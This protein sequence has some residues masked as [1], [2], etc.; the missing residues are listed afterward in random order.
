MDADSW[1]PDIYFDMVEEH[2]LKNF[3]NR[4]KLFYQ[5]PQI[6]TRNN[7]DVPVFTRV[8]DVIHSFIHVSNLFSIFNITFPLSNYTVSYNLVKRFGFWDTCADAIGED[9]HTLQKSFWKTNAE[10]K[11]VPIYTPFNQVNISTG[12]K[13]IENVLARFWQAERHAQGVAD[14]AW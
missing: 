14:I 10:V 9:F 11:T 6:F 12:D 1:A 5:P 3:Q 8:Y 7:L 2:L 4:H 13:Y